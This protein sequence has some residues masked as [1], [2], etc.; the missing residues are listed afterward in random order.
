MKELKI[1]EE[2]LLKAAEKCPQAKEVLKE[3]FPEVFDKDEVFCYTDSIFK[4][5][6]TNYTYAIIR[7]DS[8]FFMYNMTQAR[9]WSNGIDARPVQ[10]RHFDLHYHK[11]KAF[12]VT[13]GEFLELVKGTSSTKLS[14]WKFII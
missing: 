7:R 12:P 10:D 13:K 5:S 3:L 4:C 11:D 8:K 6:N 2:N 9:F 1:S 14:D